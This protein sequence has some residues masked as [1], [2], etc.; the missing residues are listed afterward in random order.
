MH[1]RLIFGNN[2]F[3][4]LMTVLLHIRLQGLRNIVLTNDTSEISFKVIRAHGEQIDDTLVLFFLTDWNLHTNR[5][6]GE[7]IKN[8]FVRT[9]K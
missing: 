4:E 8:R 6:C 3:N 7:S 2:F 5:I 9:L 1:E